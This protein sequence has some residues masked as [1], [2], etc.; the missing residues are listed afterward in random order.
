MQFLIAQWL[1]WLQ[2]FFSRKAVADRLQYMCDW[3]L[4]DQWS[5]INEINQTMTIVR[6]FLHHQVL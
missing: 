1:H 6:G 4:S 2:L 3:G 5:A